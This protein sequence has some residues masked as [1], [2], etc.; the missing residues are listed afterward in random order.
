M[1][2]NS[3]PSCAQKLEP[4]RAGEVHPESANIRP[5]AVAKTAVLLAHI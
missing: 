2:G 5:V 1:A 3:R 4:V